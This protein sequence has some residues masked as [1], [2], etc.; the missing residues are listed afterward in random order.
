MTG[1]IAAEQSI[2]P[3]ADTVGGTPPPAGLRHVVHDDKRTLKP[4][5]AVEA[6]LQRA[7][8]LALF[9]RRDRGAGHKHFGRKR[10]LA[11]ARHRHEHIA[12]DAESHFLDFTLPDRC[13]RNDLAG[14][15][16]LEGFEE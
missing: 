3:K 5:L 1:S 7:E 16:E 13:G 12:F 11:T 8:R 10:A 15:V 14:R 6:D 4:G 9:K 2:E